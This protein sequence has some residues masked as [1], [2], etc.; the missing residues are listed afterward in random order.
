MMTEKLE[1][2]RMRSTPTLAAALRQMNAGR[3][4][5]RP[6]PAVESLLPP[7]YRIRAADQADE[8]EAV[9]RV[10]GEVSERLRRLVD[11]Y[12]EWHE[13]DAPAYFDLPAEFSGNIVR[14]VERVSTVHIVFFADL[15]LPSFQ[16]AVHFWATAMVPA[17]QQREESAQTYRHFFEEVQPAMLGQWNDLIAVLARARSHLL[18]DIGFL[19]TNGAEDERMR[20]Q[21]LWQRPPVSELD[22]DLT[23]DLSTIPTLTLAI[24]FPLPAQKQPGRIRRLRRSRERRRIHQ[25]HKR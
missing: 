7:M 8:A 1:T 20:R 3:L 9:S 6:V 4:H 14:V 13:F 5:F 24:D 15:L 2:V 25:S 22:R 18:G 11:A 19:T 12:G 10:I 17:Y 16:R 23:P 21:A